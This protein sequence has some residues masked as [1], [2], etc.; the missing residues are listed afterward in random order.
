MARTTLPGL[1][2][3][4]LLGASCAQAPKDRIGILHVPDDPTK[5]LLVFGQRMT[6]DVPVSFRDGRMYLGDQL[7]DLGSRPNRTLARHE[8]DALKLALD[9]QGPTLIFLARREPDQRHM[10]GRERA[11]RGIAEI[12]AIEDFARRSPGP[13]PARGADDVLTEAARGEIAAYVRAH[14]G[15]S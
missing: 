2:L 8:Y 7:V 4:F 1:L 3:L 12:T 11:L 6:G 5:V 14:P 15:G 10:L 13:L 9:W